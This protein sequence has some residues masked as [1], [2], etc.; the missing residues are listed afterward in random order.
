[1]LVFCP[2]CGAEYPEM[3]GSYGETASMCRECGL[4]V[5]EEPA[6][7][8][9]DD[10]QVAFVLDDWPVEFRGEATAVLVDNRIPYR[11]EAG[12][13]LVVPAED[14]EQVDALLD[15]A[16][17]AV[18]EGLADDDYDEDDE[19][20]E[21]YEDALEG[22]V[23]DDEDDD[24]DDEDEGDEDGGE[25]AQ[26]AMSDLYLVADRLKDQPWDVGLRAEMTQLATQVNA[27]LPPYGIERRIWNRIG[28][29]AGAV[30]ADIERGAE[31][32]EVAASTVEL[33]QA[34]RDFV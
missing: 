12:F 19:D 5:T 31:D 11:W 33:R 9:P 10:D 32:D 18:E 26:Q 24:E 20:D 4:S 25:E 30:A 15:E 28:D 16:E 8:E 34:V 2:R 3:T 1:M 7:L 22:E 23:V 29:L 21:E 6:L 27:L 13:A 14:E 17:A